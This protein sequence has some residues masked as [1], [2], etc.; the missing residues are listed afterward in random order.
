MSHV[1]LKVRP[2]VHPRDRFSFQFCL[3]HHIR[4]AS[5]FLPEQIVT[6][7]STLHNLTYLFTYAA[8]PFLRSWQLCSPLKTPQYFMEPEGST[9][10]SQEPPT[11]S[12]PEPY[13]SNLIQLPN[14]LCL[15]LPSGLF[16]SGFPTNI[17]PHSCY[18]PRPSHPSWLDYSNYTWRRVQVMKLLIMQRYVTF[19]TEKHC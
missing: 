12:H 6:D 1:L 7:S 2:Q 8:E 14:Y 11:G 4:V 9:S 15:C 17:L 19:V 18:M 16:P 13:R 10:C 5:P 3:F